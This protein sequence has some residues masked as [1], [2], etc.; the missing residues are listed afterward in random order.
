MAL[1]AWGEQ[2]GPVVVLLVVAVVAFAYYT[3]RADFTI[4]V[5]E[6]RV[7]F[8]GRFPLALQRDATE[9]FLRDLAVTHPVRVLGDWPKGRGGRLGLRFR[10]RLSDG[11]KQ[12]VRNFLNSR[13]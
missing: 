2:A 9:F 7:E 8:R 6:G 5:R 13:A 4:R 11:Q 1:L 10:G 3:R 12:R